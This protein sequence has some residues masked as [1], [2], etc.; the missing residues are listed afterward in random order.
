MDQ[1]LRLSYAWVKQTREVVFR[2][3][4]TLP[5]QIYAREHP[6]FGFG[7]IRKLHAHVA[8][9]Y[10]W[11]VGTAGLGLPQPTIERNN[12]SNVAAM[13][14]LFAQVDAVVDDALRNFTRL[15]EV[16]EWTPPG[17]DR[18]VRVSQ[19]WLILHPLTHEFHHKGQMVA[20]GR[21][22]GYP[23]PAAYDTDLVNP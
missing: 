7:S 2:Y 1:A 22:L 16:Y 23:A 20:L 19:R 21:V 8:E 11:W 4:E 15:D 14:R 6:D 18:T 3:C 10:L 17:R 5:P 12:L 9:C 13:R